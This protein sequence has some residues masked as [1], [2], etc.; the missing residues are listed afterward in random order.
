VVPPTST[1]LVSRNPEPEMV[2]VTGLEPADIRFGLIE[3]IA[4]VGVVLPP[5]L[6]EPEP[7]PAHPL[8]TPRIPS[9]KIKAEKRT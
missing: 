9:A 8:I 6:P 7:L 1:T 2:R 3:V 5:P 4:G